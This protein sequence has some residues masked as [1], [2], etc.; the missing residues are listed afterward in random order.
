MDIWEIWW[1]V[2]EWDHLAPDR[3]GWRAPVNAEINIEVNKMSGNSWV[4][5]Q[6]AASQVGPSSM[7]LV[8]YLR[9]FIA[10]R[11]IWVLHYM[12][13]FTYYNLTLV[14]ASK[15][16]SSISSYSHY[17]WLS[18]LSSPMPIW[19]FYCS[20]SLGKVSTSNI[21]IRFL[22]YVKNFLRFLGTSHL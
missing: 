2:E 12:M 4:T 16:S 6:L 20:Q 18:W 19:S 22:K 8:S 10:D 21:G 5:E 7:E 11:Q 3:D 14:P 17:L 1:S 15:Y 13:N 9:H